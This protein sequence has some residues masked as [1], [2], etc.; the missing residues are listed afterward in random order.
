MANIKPFEERRVVL[1]KTVQRKHWV[2]ANAEIDELLKKYNTPYTGNKEKYKD[3]DKPFISSYIGFTIGK[4]LHLTGSYF[5]ID[6]KN[7]LSKRRDG[8]YPLYRFYMI[9]WLKRNTTYSLKEIGKILGNRH[10]STIINGVTTLND[11]CDTDEMIK[12]TKERYF[13]YLNNN[14]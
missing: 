10:H 3:E 13:E 4:F 14:I 9:S 7:A 1:F 11:L 5:K 2:K 12:L 6:I 8:D